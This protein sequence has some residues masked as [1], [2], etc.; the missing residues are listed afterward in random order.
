MAKLDQTAFFLRNLKDWAAELQSKFGCPVTISRD[1]TG[2]VFVIQ[3]E[4]N[5]HIPKMYRSIP[6]R[7]Q[8]IA[9]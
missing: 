3:T 1:K 8:L 4:Y 7:Q 6:V 5:I 2:Y 9:N